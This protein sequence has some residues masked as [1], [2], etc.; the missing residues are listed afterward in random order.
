M[1]SEFGPAFPKINSLFKRDMSKKGNPVIPGD[2]S[3]EEFGYLHDKLWRWTEKI[4]GT[5]TRLYWDGLTVTLGGRTDNA[6]VPAHLVSAVRDLGLLKPDK[7]GYRWPPEPNDGS[8]V[9][10]TIFGEGYGPKIQKGGGLYR[11]DV[12]FIVFDVKIGSWWLKPEDVKEIA[13][14]FG[15]ETVPEYGDWTL[16]E[17]WDKVGLGHLK[18]AR[19]PDAPMEGLVGTPVVPLFNRKGERII[20]KV[21]QKDWDDLQRSRGL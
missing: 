16:S 12:S 6:Q 8:A 18:S 9:N 19:F 21:K 7:W 10:V 15:L 1:S 5:N 3:C 2:W 4:D 20:T 17:A 11:E 13:D 14:Y